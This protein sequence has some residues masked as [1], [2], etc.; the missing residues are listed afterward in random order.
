MLTSFALA[1]FFGLET[2]QL[3]T[4]P[5]WRDYFIAAETGTRENRPLAVFV[6]KGKNGFHQVVREGKLSEDVLRYLPKQ[7]VCAYVNIDSPEGKALAGS[8]AITKGTGL[9][10]SDRT[11][12]FQVYHHNG[13]FADGATLLKHLQR[14]AGVT[15]VTRTESNESVSYYFS[16][17]SS[18]PSTSSFVPSY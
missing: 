18:R 9:V 4:E 5:V 6:G 7:Y 16:P 11:G 15:Q 13:A 1:M 12:S 17:D 8:L 2:A 10:I 14:F 3:P